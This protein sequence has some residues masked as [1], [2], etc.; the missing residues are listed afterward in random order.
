M[1][2]THF[3][4]GRISYEIKEDISHNNNFNY[5]HNPGYFISYY[6]CIGISRYDSRNKY[7]QQKNEKGYYVFYRLLEELQYE[8]VFESAYTL[9]DN[10]GNVIVYLNMNEM[11]IE[12]ITALTSWVESGNNLILFDET[13]NTYFDSDAYKMKDDKRTFKSSFLK[14]IREYEIIDENASGVLA[15]R[16]KSGNGSIVLISDRFQFNNENM[17]ELDNALKLDNIFYPFAGGKL[18][19]R[20][21][22]SKAIYDPTLIKGLFKGKTSIIALHLIIIFIILL[23][24]LGKRFYKPT[25]KNAKRVRKIS[26][27]IGAVGLFYHKA[28]AAQLIEKSDSQYFK[29]VICKNKKPS[30]LDVEEYELYSNYHKKISE[31][32]IVKRFLYR[33][34]LIKKIR[35]KN[36]DNK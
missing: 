27:H 29:Y 24:F 7:V 23:A 25:V 2:Y 5:C 13:V 11:E 8:I 36:N 21:K 34:K 22:Y 19:L 28:G 15:F 6:W 17:T 35:S 18:Y 4:T 3:F 33:Q 12:Q 26:E 9:P 14:R 31:E 32:E 20:E 30:I 1:R 10:R 16:V